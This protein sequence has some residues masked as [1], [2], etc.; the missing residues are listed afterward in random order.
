MC[1]HQKIDGVALSVIVKWGEAGGVH[2][3]GFNC[4]R[5]FR[6]LSDVY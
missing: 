6:E 5:E 4:Q 2:L 3:I 1:A